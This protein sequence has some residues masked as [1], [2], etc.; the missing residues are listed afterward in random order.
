M[1]R[2]APTDPSTDRR[3]GK[4]RDNVWRPEPGPERSVQP[5]HPFEEP[6]EKKKRPGTAQ[7]HQSAILALMWNAARTRAKRKDVPFTIDSSDIV[8]L[9]K[10]PCCGVEL[11]YS[12]KEKGRQDN[13]P[14]LDR[15]V[16]SMGYVIENISIL[17]MRCNRLKKDYSWEE[18][19]RKPKISHIA[20]W[21][22]VEIQKKLA[23]N[24]S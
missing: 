2:W 12:V 11:D 13:S 1:K 20:R 19:N 23:K 15:I 22:R 4:K 24:I 18:L 9:R 17:C 6:S 8:F 3:F 7:I 14:S 21:V 10:C 16:P 5:R